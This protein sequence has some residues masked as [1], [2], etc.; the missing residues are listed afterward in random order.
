[1]DERASLYMR[2]RQRAARCREMARA[3]SSAGVAR[4]LESIAEEYERD[5]EDLET[6]SRM[7]GVPPSPPSSAAGRDF[8]IWRSILQRMSPTEGG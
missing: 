6:R 2:L 4:E 3:A 5:A 8:G 1:M 7:A